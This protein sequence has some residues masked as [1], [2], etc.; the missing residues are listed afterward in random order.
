[1]T[2]MAGK[3]L[4]VFGGTGFLGRH[5]V[6]EGLAAGWDVRIA[7]RAPRPELFAADPVRA[8]LI[9]ADIRDPEAVAAAVHGASAVVNAVSL[10]VENRQAS[11]ES[12]HV[13][14]AEHVARAAS[15]ESARLLHVSGI[16][17]DRRSRSPYIRARALGEERV[18]EVYP[19]SV[20]LRPGALFG[21]G[22]ALLSTM[23]ALVKRLP[24]IPLFGTGDS[25]IQPAAVDD[26]ARAV[27]IALARPG[28]RAGTY[29]LGGPVVYTYRQLLEGIAARLE[30][31]R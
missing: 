20:V 6:R 10:Y 19:D 12:V 25:R 16:G 15:R 9:A 3:L 26:V 1:M 2:A 4:T 7:T 29:E 28:A 5:V 22:D 30:R 8:E 17:V 23:T 18:R 21:H 31:R 11:F 24:V 27:V 13:V 14:G